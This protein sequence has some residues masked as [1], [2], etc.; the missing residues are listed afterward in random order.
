MLMKFK[1]VCMDVSQDLLQCYNGHIGCKACLVRLET[2]PVCRISLKFKAKV[3]SDENL[4][5]MLTELRHIEKFEIF[6]QNEKLSEFFKCPHCRKIPTRK[7]VYVSETGHLCCKRCLLPQFPVIPL[8]KRI[9]LSNRSIFT[10]KILSQVSI[11]STFYACVFHTKVLC[12]AF[13]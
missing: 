2:C 12:A 13:L 6:L 11:S 3:I 1:T 4:T 9:T 10:E 8:K 7:P 5:K